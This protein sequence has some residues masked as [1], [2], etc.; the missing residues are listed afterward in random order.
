LADTK[1][2]IDEYVPDSC[3][4]CGNKLSSWQQVLLK[5]DRAL[6]CKNCWYR[7]LLDVQS[8]SEKDKA[9]TDKS[10]DEVK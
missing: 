9:Q 5:V 3:P 2:Q 10:K 1:Q 7:I 8:T 6:V 4:H